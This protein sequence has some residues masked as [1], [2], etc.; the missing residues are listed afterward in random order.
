MI[1]IISLFSLRITCH[2]PLKPFNDSLSTSES[3]ANFPTLH[4]RL[5]WIQSPLHCHQPFRVLQFLQ[6]I[7]PRISLT[8][9]L[10]LNNYH[11]PFEAQFRYHL[12]WKLSLTLLLTLLLPTSECL[13]SA[14]LAPCS[15]CCHRIYHVVLQLFSP[16]DWKPLK[17]EETVPFFY[18][19][20]PLP[21]TKSV[22]TCGRM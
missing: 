12:F 7:F 19:C 6:Q 13:L 22:H 20:L 4:N 17:W 3:N 14:P 10:C 2:S 18:L 11:C 9:I 15:S 1:L 8:W 16:I 5:F 21:D